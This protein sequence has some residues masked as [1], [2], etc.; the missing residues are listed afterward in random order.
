MP[1]TSPGPLIESFQTPK[2]PNPEL[3]RFFANLKCPHAPNPPLQPRHDLGQIIAN[4]KEMSQTLESDCT[5]VSGYLEYAGSTLVKIEN[6]HYQRNCHTF[7]LHTD[8]DID[9][10]ALEIRIWEPA[11]YKV[12]LSFREGPGTPFLSAQPTSVKGYLMVNG[13]EPYLDAG[14]AKFGDSNWFMTEALIQ[15][16]RSEQERALTMGNVEATI[17]PI[18]DLK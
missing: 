17:P 3:E 16:A 12:A 14:C 9:S 10:P 4:P 8:P 7:L 18:P 5:V 2:L 13:A 15:F 11:Q 6:S 1:S